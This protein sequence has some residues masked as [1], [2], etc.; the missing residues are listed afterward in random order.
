MKRVKAS[1]MLTPDMGRDEVGVRHPRRLASRPV[2]EARGESALCGEHIDV[3]VG[4][5][6]EGKG[7]HRLISTPATIGDSRTIDMPMI[8]VPKVPTSVKTVPSNPATTRTNTP[9]IIGSNRIEG[10]R[11]I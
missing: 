9:P 8:M 6:E 1:L 3:T 4:L 11:S 7:R 2:H 10:M 5:N